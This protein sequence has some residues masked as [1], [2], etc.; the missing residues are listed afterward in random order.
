MAF[1]ENKKVRFDYELL[2]PLEAGA[3]LY[4][5]EVKAIKKGMGSLE[6]AR[7]M[8]RGGEAFL[9]GATISPYQEKNTPDSY[10]PE[11]SRRLLLTKK[12]IATLAGLESQK[13]LTIVPIKWYNSNKKVK[14]EISVARR[15]KKY[16]KRETLKARDTKRTIERT[17]KNQY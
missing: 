8:I 9:V 16:D 11:R 1:I 7:V 15:K 3:E 4:G 14:I 6:G 13:G 12:Q 2:E 10:N 17:L 5:H